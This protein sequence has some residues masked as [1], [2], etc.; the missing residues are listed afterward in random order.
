[1]YA[2]A[3]VNWATS[4]SFYPWF[5]ALALLFAFAS[6]DWLTSFYAC[7]TVLDCLLSVFALITLE[8]SSLLFA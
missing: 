4:S 8:I 5:S 3:P 6:V 1:V 2:S 7:V